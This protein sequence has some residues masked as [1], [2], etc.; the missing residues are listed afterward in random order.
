MNTNSPADIY[1]QCPVD[2]QQRPDEEL[3]MSDHEKE[4]PTV[5]GNRP[6]VHETRK[7]TPSEA[8]VE[9]MA[10]NDVTHM[11]GLMGAAFMDA[12]DIFA[13]EIGRAACRDGKAP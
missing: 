5:S 3:L 11:F 6:V 9:T 12:M 8:F 10:A 2:G 13:P 4:Q 7:M 1:K